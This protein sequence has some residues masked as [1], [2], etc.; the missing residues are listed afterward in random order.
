MSFAEHGL[1]LL[2]VAMLWFAGTALVVALDRRALALAGTSVVALLSLG[3]LVMLRDSASVH[4]A[5]GS[6]AAAFGLWAWHEL[7]FLSGV[8][9]GPSRAPCPLGLSAW[10]RFKASAATVIH[11]EI[12]LALTLALL[13]AISWGHANATGSYAFA[14]LFAMRLSTKLNIFLGV[15]NFTPDLLPAQLAYLKT[16]FRTARFNALMPFSLAGATALTGALWAANQPLLGALAL[17][18][19]VE[20]LF[21]ILPFRDGALWRWAMPKAAPV[22]NRI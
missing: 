13:L 4:A 16:H 8:I 22:R 6:F 19:L 3:A 17:L 10:A 20:H 1:P 21:L 18:G 9:A 11:H 12:A 7:S 15:P 2:Y 5:Y 14:I